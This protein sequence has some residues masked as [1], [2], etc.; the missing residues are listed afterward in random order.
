[1]SPGITARYGAPTLTALRIVAGIGFFTHGAQK[2]FGWFGGMGPEGGTAE[3]M[4]R[5]WVAG[6]IEV[7]AA[8]LLILGLFTRMTA[9]LS[10]GEMAVAYFWIHVPGGGLWWWANGGELAMLYAFTW[11]YFAA[12][13]GGPYSVDAR[14]RRPPVW[15]AGIPAPG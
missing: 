1:M 12:A 4:S 8:P 7:V 10:A 9:L 2:L 5:F 3:V 15:K 13:G 11:L 6:I 14:F